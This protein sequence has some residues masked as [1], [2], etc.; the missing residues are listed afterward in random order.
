LRSF[1]ISEVIVNVHHFANMVIDYLKTN[2]NFGMRIEISRED[3]LLDTGGGLKKPPGFSSTIPLA[4]IPAKPT[5]PSSSTTSTSS[6][7]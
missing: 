2:K 4:V 6:A 3:V 7:P 1:G 5:S